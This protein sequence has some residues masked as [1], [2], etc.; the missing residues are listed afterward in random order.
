MTLGT[1]L[2]NAG[3][4]V[5]ILAALA[6]LASFVVLERDHPADLVPFA[7]LFVVPFEMG[8][9]LARMTP[10]RG[11]RLGLVGF[12]AGVVVVALAPVLLLAFFMAV[13]AA[14]AFAMPHLGRHGL[15][16]TP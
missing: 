16:P 2:F 6:A 13:G 8:F 9:V 11:A 14:V 4:A 12:V 15:E 5:G 1:R 10:W 3:T 7:A